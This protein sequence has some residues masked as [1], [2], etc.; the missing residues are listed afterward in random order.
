MGIEP[1]LI[2]E[3]FHCMC[4]YVCVYAHARVCTLL[5]KTQSKFLYFASLNIVTTQEYSKYIDLIGYP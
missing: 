5:L 2:Y 3:N 4:I 1:F